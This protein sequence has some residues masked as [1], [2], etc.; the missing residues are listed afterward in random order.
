MNQIIE[1]TTKAYCRIFPE[2][3]DDFINDGDETIVNII[4]DKLVE[5]N[6][7][8]TIIDV[9]E[10]KQEIKKVLNSP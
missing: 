9:R 7:N 1:K 6:K 10:L 5:I 2:L 4:T 3:K 8:N